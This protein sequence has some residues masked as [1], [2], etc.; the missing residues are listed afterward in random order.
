MCHITG[1]LTRGKLPIR[2]GTYN[3]R[4]GCNGELESAL[5]GVSQANID[6]GIF[7]E[8]KVADVIYTRRWAGYSIVVTDEAEPTPRQSGSVSLAGTEFRRGGHP[9]VRTQRRRLPAGEKGISGD[10]F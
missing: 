7:Q 2:F 6:L 4:N 9:S 5:T 10:T 8:T 1:S 3:T